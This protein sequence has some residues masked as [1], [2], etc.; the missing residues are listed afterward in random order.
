M[1]R[2]IHT[3]IHRYVY[4]RIDC[5]HIGV[6]MASGKWC[7]QVQEPG[8]KKIGKLI[9]IWGRDIWLYLWNRCEV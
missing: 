3:H 9:R 6:Y 2:L 1:Y 4:I 7:D 5:I 8:R